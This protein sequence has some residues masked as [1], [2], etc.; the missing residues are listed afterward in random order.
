[1]SGL[2]DWER[3]RLADFERQL[4]GE[5]PGLADLLRGSVAARPRWAR[6]G[7]GWLLAVA[8]VV[9]VFG[10]S[11]LRDGSVTLMGLLVLGCC[12]VPFWGAGRTVPVSRS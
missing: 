6:R 10:G 2:T 3:D 9:L 12:W 7:L 8:G 1:M 11:V 4:S 5:D